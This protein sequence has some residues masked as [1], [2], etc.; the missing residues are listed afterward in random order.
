[1]V[2]N[3]KSLHVIT[4]IICAVILIVMGISFATRG[5]SSAS[6]NVLGVVVSPVQKFFSSVGNG[7]SGFFGFVFDMKDFQQENLDE[8]L[9]KTV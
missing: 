9:R 6:G 8:M 7:V 3:K 2:R 5:T 1:M 4:I